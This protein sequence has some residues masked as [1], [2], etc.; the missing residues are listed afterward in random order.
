MNSGSEAAPAVFRLPRTSY[1]LVLFVAFGTVPLAFT[2]ANFHFDGTG[3][4]QGAPAVYGWQLVLLTLPLLAL[5]Y[6]A[7]TA[8]FVDATGIR[9]RA[10]FGSRQMPWTAIRGLSTDKR[11]VYA[12]LADGAVRL[13]C[14]HVNTLAALARASGGHL[15]EIA[16]PRPKFAP[17][18]AQRRR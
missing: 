5:V 15:P 17:S 13:P 4:S 1:L 9:V 16:D 7:R 2:A 18:R 12:V 11:T 3:A 6:I 10:L 14:V 8:T